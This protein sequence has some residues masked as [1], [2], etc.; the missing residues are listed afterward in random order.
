MQCHRII[1]LG[2]MSAPVR[3]PHHEGS[4]TH[5]V[6]SRPM[7]QQRVLHLPAVAPGTFEVHGVT[8]YVDTHHI[9]HRIEETMSPAICRT[10]IED[11]ASRRP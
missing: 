3:C 8:V 5:C 6:C 9:A 7:V 1:Q 2:S 10:C 11:A 4:H